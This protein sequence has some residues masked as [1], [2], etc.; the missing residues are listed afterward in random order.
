MARQ[1]YA[2][3]AS[4]GH[5]GALAKLRQFAL[6]G[7]RLSEVQ[8]IKLSADGHKLMGD[9]SR[10]LVLTNMASRMLRDSHNAKQ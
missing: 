3:A 4:H 7:D 8:F 9:V 2:F 5:P 6:D 1:Y 10:N